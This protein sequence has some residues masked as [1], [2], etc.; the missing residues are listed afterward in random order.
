MTKWRPENFDSD[1]PLYLALAEAVARDIAAGRLKPGQRLPTHRDLADDIGVNVSTVTRG[2]KEAERRGLLSGTV[3]RGTFVAADAAAGASL[4]RSDAS[5]PV[6]LEMGLA[7]PLAAG[8]PD[9]SEGL[10]AMSR[11]ENVK[12]YLNYT[13]PAGLPEHRAVGAW[14]C[15][16]YGLDASPE[17]V[18]IFAGAQHALCCSL[19]ALF[20]AGDRIA[21]DALTYPGLKSLSHML[22]LRLT[23]IV[24]DEQ[25]LMPEGLEAAC[26]RERIKGLYLMP[27]VQNPTTGCMSERRRD[28][29]AEVARR[30]D[31]LV[32]EDD[33]YALTR[34]DRPGPIGSRLTDRCVYIAGLSKAMGPGLR[35]SF[36]AAARRWRLRL[37]RSVLNSIWMVPPLNVALACAWIEDGTADRAVAAKRAEAARRMALA[38]RILGEGSFVGPAS[39]FFVWLTL[40]PPWTGAEFERRAREA[41]V[42]IFSADR[43]AVGGA[44]APAAARLSLSGPET[45]ESLKNGLE[46][47]AD[48]L[49]GHLTPIVPI[50]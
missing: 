43:F 42:N 20:E 38:R 40:P 39:G 15:G 9:L 37:T 34:A 16:R 4:V 45:M 46:I 36:A 13:H 17:D 3:G 22:G 25:G 21:V 8:D 33:A 44:P 2:Y 6:L 41:G 14:W 18:V 31:L 7:P 10:A 5:G 48:I 24:M 30:H 26:R 1:R 12:A 35:V 47:L 49:A 23:A 50:M 11:R 29:V 32:I 27:G 28:L 19:A